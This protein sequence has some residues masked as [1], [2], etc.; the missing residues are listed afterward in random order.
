VAVAVKRTSK[1][2]KHVT[3]KSKAVASKAKRAATKD[4]TKPAGKSRPTDDPFSPAKVRAAIEA[5]IQ[6]PAKLRD[7]LDRYG[8]FIVGPSVSHFDPTEGQPGTLLTIHGAQFSTVRE[9]NSVTVGG[10][11]AFVASASASELKVVTASTVRNGRVKVKV[12]SRTATS[13]QD[14]RVRGYPRGGSGEDGPPVVFEG[15]GN[16]SPG[17]V[18]PIGTVRVLV[19]LV[20]PND[21]V[22]TAAAR[23]SVVDAWAAVTRYYAQAS[24]GRTD[25][26]VDVT[27][28]W[29]TLDIDK[30]SLLSD[31]NID[32]A[33]L[34]RVE[35]FAAQGAVDE[36]F[37][38][39]DYEMMAAVVFLNGTGIRAWGGWSKQDFVYNN[40]LPA[41]DPN[42]I[43]INLSADHEVNLIA[44]NEGANWGRCAHE[45]GHNVVS[46][47]SILGD[48]SATLGEDVYATGLVDPSAASARQF[49][50]MGSHDLHPLFSGYHLEKLGYYTDSKILDLTWDRNAF[51]QEYDVVAHGLAEDTVASRYHL[52]KIKV[53]DGLYYYVQ[54]RQRPGTTT[55]VFDENIPLA[56]APNEGGLIVTAVITDTLNSNQQTRLITLL[57]PQNVLKQGDTA[58]DPA[59]ALK[60]SVI[61]GGVQARPLVCRVRIEWAQAIADDPAGTFDL[62]LTPWDGNYQSPDIWV[63][64]APYGSYDNPL[65]AEGRPTGNGDRPRPLEINNFHARVH[66]SGATGAANV[67]VT[68]YAVFPPGVGDNGNWGPLATQTIPAIAQ[69]GHAD[70]F[71]NWTPV[72]GQHTC[73][74]VHVSQQLGEI[75][76]GNNSAQENVFDFEAPSASPAAPVFVRVA[77]RNPL[78]ERRMVIVGI[79]GVPQ[80]YRVH[81]PHAWVWL[82]GRAERHFDVLVIPTFDFQNYDER[83][84]SRVAPVRLR[85][86]LPRQ[87]KEPIMPD[88]RLAGSRFYP[89]GGL[90][91]RVHVVRQAKLTLREDPKQAEKS[92]TVAL[93]GKL[94]PAA[95]SQKVRVEL[96]D[97]TGAPRMTEVA[98][99]SAG[100]FAA[101]FDLRYQASLESDRKKWRKATELVHGTYRAQ[102]HIVTVDKVSLAESPV[103]FVTR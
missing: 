12:G 72:V 41:G 33:Q 7:W 86:W 27:T 82:D 73:L 44:I 25:V 65:D 4:Q 3:V 46:A 98:T 68:F 52:I 26:Q 64:R 57:H 20:T 14:F 47:P 88:G 66:V 62:S 60:I 75:S 2:A 32:A 95:G 49:D 78:D 19:S 55:Q 10:E 96:L 90:L 11:P 18:D 99:S 56:G 79:G 36:G 38:L 54:A 67:K 16:G 37:D 97:P 22:P 63:D 101:A 9:E 31:D 58:E 94:T 43:D 76:G 70:V 81:F 85:G 93:L 28:N 48:G 29:K 15:A 92:T 51:S 24:Y 35:A 34:D 59:R 77:L 8:P 45:F 5:R 84:L 50:L 6:T 83:K 80:G 100:E 17:D 87:Y 89:I 102:A 23:T 71:C 39:D 13:A 69:D 74:K 42:R 91:S 103:V 1:Q 21:Q 61:D 53:A 30:A 40:G